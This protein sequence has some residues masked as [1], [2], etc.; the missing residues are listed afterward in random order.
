MVKRCGADAMP[1]ATARAD[2]L[3]EEGGWQGANEWHRILDCIE[4]IQAEALSAMGRPCSESD[5]LRRFDVS[6]VT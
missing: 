3:T 5:D 4:R 1:E 6:P 2:E